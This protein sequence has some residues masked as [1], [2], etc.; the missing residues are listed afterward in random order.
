MA[1][2]TLLPAGRVNGA[3]Y[4][5]DPFDVFDVFRDDVDR[6]WRRQWTALPTMLSRPTGQPTPGA[7]RLDV[8]EKDNTLIV[9]AELPGVKKEDVQVELD[10]GTLVIKGETKDASEAKEEAYYRMERTYSAYDRRLPLPFDVTPDQVTATMQDGVL[11]IHI[12][13][14]AEATPHATR[15]TVG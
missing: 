10:N 3:V 5:W 7:P 13:R 12:P 14:P 1:T 9:K 6:L 2:Q 4:S 8:L 15:I 11:E